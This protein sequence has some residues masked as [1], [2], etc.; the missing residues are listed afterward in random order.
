MKEESQGAAGRGGKE[1]PS[2][3]THLQTK[4]SLQHHNPS[5]GLQPLPTAPGFLRDM[6]VIQHPPCCT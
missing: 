1:T 5:E 2:P 6:A 3:H 4:V